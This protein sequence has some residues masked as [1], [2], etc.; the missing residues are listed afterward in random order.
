M[1][2]IAFAYKLHPRYPLIFLGNRDEFHA[3]PTRPA[4][5]W[6]EAPNLLGGKDLQAGGS[7]LG[8]NRQGYLAAVTNVREP[9]V[10]PG[11]RSRGALVTDY[12]ITHQGRLDDFF[13]SIQGQINEYSGFNLLLGRFDDLHYLSNRS[14][15]TAP[16]PLEPG[17]YGLSNHLLDTPWPKVLRTK[18]ALEQQLAHSEPDEDALLAIL[19][20]PTPAPDHEL[21]DTGVGLANERFLSSA[22]IV[23]PIYG[24]R[25]SSLILVAEDQTITF[26]EQNYSP[27]GTPDGRQ[28]FRFRP[29]E[30]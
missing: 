4:Q 29:E 16:M 17:L 14:P 19:Q 27:S 11:P 8:L 25:A 13:H 15:S 5:F 23:S 21:P 1:C 20:D 7:W 12:L 22:F 3:R 10:P 9:A 30:C 2:L 26:I 6:P 18:Q 28:K 24:T